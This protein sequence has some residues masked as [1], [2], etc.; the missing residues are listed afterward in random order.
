MNASLPCHMPATPCHDYV[1]SG[2]SSCDH[3][4]SHQGACTRAFGAGDFNRLCECVHDGRHAH[5]EAQTSLA[6]WYLGIIAFAVIDALANFSLQQT[7]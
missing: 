7:W 4:P 3:W 2:G 5:L 1:T 6:D